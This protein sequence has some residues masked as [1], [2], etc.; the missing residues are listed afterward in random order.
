MCSRWELVVGED[1]AVYDETQLDTLQSAI[2]II[3]VG[4][5][6]YPLLLSRILSWWAHGISGYARSSC[7]TI[8]KQSNEQT[9]ARCSSLFDMPGLE[10]ATRSV[11]VLKW[12]GEEWPGILQGELF[13]GNVNNSIIYLA[14]SAIHRI[15]SWYRLYSKYSK[16]G[17]QLARYAQFSA[18]YESQLWLPGRSF[19]QEDGD[20]HLC[21]E[22]VWMLPRIWI[23]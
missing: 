4:H 19:Q 13:C 9:W 8:P 23:W 10:I 20:K 22:S 21:H 2:V 14:K 3:L 17:I 11:S 18:G 15:T 7:N 6:K 5:G 1:D 16:A 12:F